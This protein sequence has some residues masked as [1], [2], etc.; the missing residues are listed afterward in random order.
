MSAPTSCSEHNA[1]STG[2]EALSAR[3]A[4]GR[5]PPTESVQLERKMLPNGR[6]LGG[7]VKKPKGSR[8]SPGD[9]RYS[10]GGQ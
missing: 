1:P 6:G 9:V 2:L 10:I 5:V 7:P 8:N 3:A 4:D